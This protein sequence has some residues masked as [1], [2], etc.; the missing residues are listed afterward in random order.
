MEKILIGTK[1]PAKIEEI[2]FG[3]KGYIA[4]ESNKK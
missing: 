1:N 4:K 3:L 2:Y